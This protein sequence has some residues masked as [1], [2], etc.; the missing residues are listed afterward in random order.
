MDFFKRLL[1]DDNS[2]TRTPVQ[3]RPA[4]RRDLTQ[5]E[6]AIER[7]RYLVRTAPPET[8]E[9]VHAEAFAKLTPEQRQVVLQ[10][11]TQDLPAGEQRTAI[12]AGDDPRALARVATRAEMRDPGT[13]ERTWNRMPAGGGM[14]MGGF[15]AGNFMSTIAGVMVGS[16]IADA[17]LGD[18]G[19]DLGLGDVAAD[20]GAAVEEGVGDVAGGFGDLGGDF[21]GF[22]DF[23]GDFGGD[24]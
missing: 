9:E 18:S 20:A 5:D 10:E 8:I 12:A 21:G 4:A 13:L 6:Q 17:F 11:L 19:F 23:G 2:A 14:G 22:G 7:Y 24:F 1:G 3:Q 15:M 16:M